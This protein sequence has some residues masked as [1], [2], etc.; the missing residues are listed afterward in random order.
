MHGSTPL[1][2]MSYSV[3]GSLCVFNTN[4]VTMAAI[5]PLTYELQQG[6]VYLRW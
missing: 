2:F 4:G 6:W 1:R 3:V 5:G